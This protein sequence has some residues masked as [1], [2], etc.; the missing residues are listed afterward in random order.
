MAYGDST[1]QELRTSFYLAE[2]E[3]SAGVSPR[4]LKFLDMT[5]F[6]N[7]FTRCGYQI[8]TFYTTVFKECFENPWMLIEN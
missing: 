6:G 7:I 4:T 3:R 8:P 1:L 5:T 2:N